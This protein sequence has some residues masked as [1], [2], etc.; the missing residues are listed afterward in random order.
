[1]FF[2]HKQETLSPEQYVES[3]WQS[4]LTRHYCADEVAGSIQRHTGVK[5]SP[6]E[7]VEVVEKVRARHGWGRRERSSYFPS[8]DEE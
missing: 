2:K 8:E 4:G 1:M 3:Q 6:D 7:A 5:L